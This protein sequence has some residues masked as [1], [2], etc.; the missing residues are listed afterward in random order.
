MLFICYILL[1]I[2]YYYISPRIPDLK[3]LLYREKKIKKNFFSFF[4][5]LPIYSN[6]CL[7][8]LGFWEKPRQNSPKPPKSGLRPLLFAFFRHVLLEIML[9]HNLGFWE[10]LTLHL[11]EHAILP[12]KTASAISRSCRCSLSRNLSHF[13][14][15]FSAVSFL[16]FQSGILGEHFLP[17]KKARAFASGYVLLFKM[18]CHRYS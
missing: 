3:Q 1:F 17:A 18:V 5:F 4:L 16:R 11:G 2:I 6:F 7:G 12:A 9:S 13:F 15:F 14:I 10:R 8:D